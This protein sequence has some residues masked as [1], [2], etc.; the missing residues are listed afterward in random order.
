YFKVKLFADTER[1]LARLRALSRLLQPETDYFVTFDGNENFKTFEAFREFWEKASAEPALRELWRRILLVEQPVH[2]ERTLSDD[3]GTALR[4]WP[5]RPRLIIDES[6]GA[7]GDL[8]RALALGYAGT[9]H[10]NCK[11]II[12]GLANACL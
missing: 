2:R 7:V 12:K 10:K 9:S 6:D 11:G 4:A 3:V 5:D 8:P 1:D